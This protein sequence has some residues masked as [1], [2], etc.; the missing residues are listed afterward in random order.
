MRE[1]EKEG[2]SDANPRLEDGVRRV[3]IPGLCL[4]QQAPRGWT[5]KIHADEPP[6]EMAGV[7][8]VAH[9]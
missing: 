9:R 8:G 1:E 4:D 5:M 6:P 2:G 3:D 7:L